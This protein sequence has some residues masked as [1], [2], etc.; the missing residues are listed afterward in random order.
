MYVRHYYFHLCFTTL[1]WQSVV[2]EVASNIN[3]PWEC[4]KFVPN[5]ELGLQNKTSA[6][7]VQE[8]TSL[9]LKVTSKYY[10]MYCSVIYDKN[11]LCQKTK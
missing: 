7:H 10:Y 9:S 5:V 2:P 3:S 4:A 1:T 11:M 6:L 8:F